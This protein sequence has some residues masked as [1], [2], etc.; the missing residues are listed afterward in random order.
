LE[1]PKGGS[2]ALWRGLTA[3]FDSNPERQARPECL[4]R[5]VRHMDETHQTEAEEQFENK[6]KKM[7]AASKLCF[8]NEFWEAGLILLFSCIDSMAWLWRDP[9][10]PD[11]TGSDFMGW[12]DRYMLPSK[13]LGTNAVDLYGA[14][15]GLLHSMTGE[16]KKHRQQNARKLFYTR[17]IDD[18]ER[19]LIQLRMNEPQMPIFVNVDALHA[20]LCDALNKFVQELDSDDALL[21]RVLTR[22]L[23]SYFSEAYGVFKPPPAPPAP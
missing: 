23:D 21:D 7:L 20:A 10:H 14:R 22:V 9:A 12:V 11:V 1:P 4:M 3:N 16:S 17:R 8:D 6:V 2:R 18:Q 19:V 13:Y 15:C 5:K